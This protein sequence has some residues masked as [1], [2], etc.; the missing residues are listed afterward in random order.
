M[1]EKKLD[2]IGA[3][4]LRD[5]LDKANKLHI[6]KDDYIQTLKTDSGWYLIY[7]SQ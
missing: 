4:N 7:E 1:K 6:H 2:H 3:T 5:L